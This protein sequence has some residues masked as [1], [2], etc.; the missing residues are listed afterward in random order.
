MQEDSLDVGTGLTGLNLRHSSVP[1]A[2]PCDCLT[3]IVFRWLQRMLSPA[4][5][6]AG[7]SPVIENRSSEAP[8]KYP[9][10]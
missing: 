6:Q 4:A 8:A 1:G 2:G 5:G 3:I 7:F 9:R 10:D